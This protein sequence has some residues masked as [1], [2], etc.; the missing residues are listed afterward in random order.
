MDCLGQF[1][2]SM[3]PGVGRIDD[4]VLFSLKEVERWIA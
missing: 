4:S 1:H 3:Q 2:K